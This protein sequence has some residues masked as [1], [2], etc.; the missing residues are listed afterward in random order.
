MS[1]PDATL[2]RGVTTPSYFSSYKSICEWHDNHR[3]DSLAPIMCNY[4]EGKNCMV[5]P[6][7]ILEA[8][9][10]WSK[11]LNETG[12][13][14][15]IGVRYIAEDKHIWDCLETYSCDIAVINP[16]SNEL[17]VINTRYP[18]KKVIVF[19]EGFTESIPKVTE[20]IQNY[21]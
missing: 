16:D 12:I 14:I 17:D 4:A 13:L 1:N 20:L 18:D 5:N 3:F 15:L 11:T 19:K 8:Q 7:V 9:D 10:F 2:I 21:S 6:E